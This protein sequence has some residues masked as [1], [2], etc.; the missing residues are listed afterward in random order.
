MHAQRR[1]EAIRSTLDPESTPSA[2][3][4]AVR[5]CEASTP[6]GAILSTL[7]CEDFLGAVIE[8]AEDRDPAVEAAWLTLAAVGATRVREILAWTATELLDGT[9]VAE[10]LL[11]HR[12]EIMAA[13]K[14][15]AEAASSEEQ[16]GAWLLLS[17]LE[18]ETLSRLVKGRPRLRACWQRLGDRLVDPLASSRHAAPAHEA[19]LLSAPRP[20]AA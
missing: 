7:A 16:W 8:A 6:I 15:R 18:E 1:I 14:L 10:L 12:H 13:C 4:A 20:A 19:G 2:V 9:A 3:R 5:E 11:S 17:H